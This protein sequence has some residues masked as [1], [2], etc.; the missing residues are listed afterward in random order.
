MGRWRRQQGGTHHKETQS[1][2]TR[3]QNWKPPVYAWQSSVPSWEKKFCTSIGLVP[4]RKLLE[5]KKCIYLYNNVVQWNDSAGEEAFHNAKK[6]F[7]A[8]INGLP[9]DIPLP[10]PDI[11]I[12]EVDW[13]SSIDPELLLNLEQEPKAPSEGDKD[14]KAVILADSLLLNQSFCCTGWGEAEED[15]R[16]T[17]DLAWHPGYGNYNQ[18]VNNN[19]GYWEHNYGQS[20]RAIEDNGWETY[21]NDSWGWNQWEKNYNESENIDGGRAGGCWRMWDNNS[22][23]EVSDR[24]MSRYKT[25]RFHGNDHHQM[26]RGRKDGRVRRKVN[27]AYE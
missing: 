18:A 9:C 20:N 17:T 6:R 15:L 4:W 21:Q 12:D 8:E 16:K 27:L 19:N 10:D 5:T 23:R 26:G 24:Y 3:S 11:Y 25:S 7:W 14:E 13:N 22:R 2:G 1:Q